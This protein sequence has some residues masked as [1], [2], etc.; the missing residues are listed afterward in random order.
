VILI[1]NITEEKMLER[2]R[3]EF[4]TIASHELRT[5]LTAIQGFVSLLKTYFA[6]R[7][8][9]PEVNH[10]IDNIGLSSSRLLK[11]VNDFLNVSRLEQGKIE[12][13]TEIFD[14]SVAIDEV[15]HE[16]GNLA[17]KKHIYLILKKQDTAVLYVNADRDKI[18]QI[19]ANI[20]GN[21]IKFTNQGGITVT[22]EEN[23][24]LVRTSIRD[25]GK[26]IPQISQ[27]L[28]FRKFQ[29]AENNL[30]TRDVN[31]GTGLGLYISKKFIEKMNG[32]IR[33]EQSK[34]N[35]GSTFV[36]SLPK[37]LPA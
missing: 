13:K 32:T 10:I 6:D 19:S 25:T 36:F 16:I 18:K 21:A 24:G 4:F 20:I 26:G 34:E 23:D 9:D 12:F 22:V 31:N 28:L 8:S 33:L 11:L 37:I 2:T 3:N 29:Q 14:I 35:E 30:L 7:I 17:E 15:I 27:N 1:D 5:P